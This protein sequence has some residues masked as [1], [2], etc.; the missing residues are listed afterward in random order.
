MSEINQID[1]G[2]I[3][4]GC[5]LFAVSLHLRKDGKKLEYNSGWGFAK[6]LTPTGKILFFVGLFMALLPAIRF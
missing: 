6:N 2:L 4:F 1:L 3:A 5:I